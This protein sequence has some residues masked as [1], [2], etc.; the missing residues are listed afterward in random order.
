MSTD[1]YII[2]F[3]NQLIHNTKQ[4]SSYEEGMV[5]IQS[6]YKAASIYYFYQNYEFAFKVINDGLKYIDSIKKYLVSTNQYDK[7]N[8]HVHVWR[9]LLKTL[10]L[11]IMKHITSISV[12]D[13]ERADHEL[14][15]E[16]NKFN[17]P[18]YGSFPSSAVLLFRKY[19]LDIVS[20]FNLY[21]IYKYY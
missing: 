2:K 15:E 9:T 3:H 4:P 16:E 6:Y 7:Q 19:F 14:S 13:I 8:K 17:V 5:F 12:Q 18:E 1:T 21:N 11:D 10:K 20:I